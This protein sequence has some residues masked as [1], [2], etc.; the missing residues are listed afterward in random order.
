MNILSKSHFTNAPIQHVKDFY[1]V[2]K[3]NSFVDTWIW[4]HIFPDSCLLFI[5]PINTFTL[6]GSP[7]YGYILLKPPPV[8]TCQPNKVRWPYCFKYQKPSNAFMNYYEV[9]IRYRGSRKKN[10]QL[11]K[12]FLFEIK[13]LVN[14]WFLICSEATRLFPRCQMKIWPTGNKLVFLYWCNARLL[15]VITMTGGISK[16]KFFSD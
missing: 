10:H 8:L 12:Y 6:I 15:T 9:W 1:R 13:I 14:V 3:K 4:T 16:S 7:Q 2:H 11:Q 5:T